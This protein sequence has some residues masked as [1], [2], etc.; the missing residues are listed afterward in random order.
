MILLPLT[1]RDHLDPLMARI[2]D[3]MSRERVK[4]LPISVSLGGATKT[5]VDES[6]EKVFDMAEDQMYRRKISEKSSYHHRS[7][8]LIVEGLYSKS[9]EEKGHSENVS[10]LSEAIGREMGL[11][12]PDLDD[13]KT[14]GVIHDIGKIG[15]SDRI[16][17][18]SGPLDEDEWQEM[19]RHPEIGYSILST[20]NEYSPFAEIVLSHHERW[21]GTGY[22]KGLKRGEIPLFSR[23]LAVAEAY[24]AMVS[25]RSYRKAMGREEAVAELRRCAGTQFDP[26]VVDVFIEK[27]FGK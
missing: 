19:K 22:P 21:D 18:K 7:V 25:G 26:E 23:I 13:L 24:D 11:G 4:D 27:V 12:Q 20:V 16:L 9:P 8:N 14:A 15:V 17:E 5:D 3:A 10:A 2:S 6:V 1:D